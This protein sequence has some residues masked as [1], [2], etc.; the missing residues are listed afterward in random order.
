MMTTSQ[1]FLEDGWS[2]NEIVDAAEHHYRP[3]SF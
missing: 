1:S 3:K 2:A